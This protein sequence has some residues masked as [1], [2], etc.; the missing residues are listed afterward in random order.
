MISNG[1][2]PKNQSG[3]ILVLALLIIAAVLGAVMLFN[4]FIIQEIKQSRL[5][6]WSIQSYYLAESGAEKS[7][8]QVRHQE[9]IVDCRL[10]EEDPGLVCNPASNCSCQANGYCANNN[11][12]PCVLTSGDLGSRG[13]WQIE[14]SQEEETSILLKKG[15]SFQIDLFNPYQ[16]F[17]SNINEIKIT[18]EITS[19]L[20]LYGELINLTNILNVQ[21]PSVSICRDQQPILKTRLDFA[22]PALYVPLDILAICSYT[23][24]LNYPLDSV[25]QTNITTINVYNRL[26]DGT[27]TPMVIP[28]RLIIDSRAQFGNSLQ[29]VRVRAPMRPPLAGL[30]DFVLFSEEQIIK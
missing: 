8:Y 28:S 15:E 14:A 21:D 13:G 7:L 10:L 12:V 22:E 25:G 23:F 19:G 17:K 26:V 29:K 30:Y 20:I 18:S 9:A 1:V 2:N 16:V 3:M 4:S 6:D 11:Q 5:I 27:L 24:R